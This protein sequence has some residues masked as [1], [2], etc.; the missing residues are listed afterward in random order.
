VALVVSG[1]LS[2]AA[3]YCLNR[4]LGRS[5]TFHKR[6]AAYVTFPL[7]RRRLAPWLRCSTTFSV[8]P[9][10]CGLPLNK[11]GSGSR[12]KRTLNDVVRG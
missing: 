7:T 2:L 3:V 6:P 8:L 10:T 1:F 4:Y 12:L 5:T 11:A 9:S